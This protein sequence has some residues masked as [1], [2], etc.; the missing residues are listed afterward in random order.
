MGFKNRF[1]SIL[2]SI[3]L[4]PCIRG[5]PMPFIVDDPFIVSRT[6]FVTGEEIEIVYPIRFLDGYE[7]LLEK[8]SPDSMS[9]YPFEIVD[10]RVEREHKQGSENYINLVYTLRHIGEK[11]GPIKIPA[12]LF[13]YVKKEP[14]KST[15]DLEVRQFESKEIVLSYVSTLTED[16]DDIR[17]EI[18]FGQFKN[19]AYFFIAIAAAIP[20]I[21]VFFAFFI[22]FRRP[23]VRVVVAG[24]E[25]EKKVSE[26]PPY[27]EIVASRRKALRELWKCLKKLEA[28]LHSL[29]EEKIK[30]LE[31]EVFQSIRKLLV[32]YVP[33]ANFS[34]TPNDF[35]NK[36]S[37]LEIR[38]RPF[39]LALSSKLEKY[40]V[41]VNSQRSFLFPEGVDIKDV[42]LA[43]RE[44]Y[45]LIFLAERF[46]LHKKIV[47]LSKLYFTDVVNLI[48]KL[49]IVAKFIAVKIQFFRRRK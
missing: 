39:L 44:V 32:A 2:A 43:R 34:Y 25:K 16:A 29:D 23:E 27:L 15:R 36:I 3:F 5:E 17:D 19:K 21:F 11:K 13:Y 40:Q 49:V 10:F 35:I 9:F 24:I 33:E 6:A 4:V 7:F 38:Y 18:D 8:A 31:L 14:G 26:A 41:Y 45:D 46:R 37:S 30:E 20:G 22:L 48:S 28:G 1:I 42:P 12:Q 47:Y